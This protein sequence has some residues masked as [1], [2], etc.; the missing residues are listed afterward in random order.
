MKFIGILLKEGRKE[1]LKK[2][3]STKF[4]EEDL[5]FI[6]RVKQPCKRDFGYFNNEFNDVYL[7]KKDIG[8][9]DISKSIC[10]GFKLNVFSKFLRI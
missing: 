5:E 8:V 2:K 10:N 6:G 1:D 3:Y 4:N 7:V 9:S